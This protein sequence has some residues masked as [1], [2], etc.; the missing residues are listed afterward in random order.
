MRTRVEYKYDIHPFTKASF[1]H[2]EIPIYNNIIE[3][4]KK[5][6]NELHYFNLVSWDLALDQKKQ[7]RS[8]IGKIPLMLKKW[9]C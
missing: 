3:T 4:V 8:M 5:L 6:H 1:S 2:I 7:I 9:H